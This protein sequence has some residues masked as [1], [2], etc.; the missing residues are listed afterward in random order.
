MGQN[1]K[2]RTQQIDFFE[3]RA[4]RKIMGHRCVQFQKCQKRTQQINFFGT[5]NFHDVTSHCLRHWYIKKI[6]N[7]KNQFSLC[8]LNAK[9]LLLLPSLW[10]LLMW[11]LTAVALLDLLVVRNFVIVLL[12][13]IFNIFSFFFDQTS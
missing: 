4:F 13:S 12:L 9:P 6:T 7:P 5:E 8:L 1:F 10:I 11:K 2:K 3:L